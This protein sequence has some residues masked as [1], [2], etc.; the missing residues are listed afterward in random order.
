MKVRER[1]QNFLQKTMYNMQNKDQQQKNNGVEEDDEYYDDDEEYDDEE[2]EDDFMDIANTTKVRPN[3]TTAP[4]P[5]QGDLMNNNTNSPKNISNNNVSKNNNFEEESEFNDDRSVSS[6]GSGISHESEKLDLLTK[7]DNLRSRGHIIRDFDLTSKL[8]DIKKET[9]RVQRQIAVSS[10]IKFQQKMLMALVSGLEYT[11]KRF[12]PFSID[13]DGWSENVFENIEDFNNVFERLYDKYR[14]RGEMAPEI[15][16]M[17]TLAGSAFMF[18]MSNHLFKQMSQPFQGQMRNLRQSVKA[19]FNQTK[20]NQQNT[21][22]PVTSPIP[23]FQ[24]LGASVLNS[25]FKNTTT[26]KP[27][28]DESNVREVQMD[29]F[30]NLSEILKNDKDDDPL[31]DQDRFSIASS[32]SDSVIEPPV[33]VQE[34]KH[35]KKTTKNN[36]KRSIVL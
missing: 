24:D 11:N 6:V 27:S 28:I 23:S 7:L 31:L 19:A 18:N 30:K 26:T 1:S 10:S 15:E 32:S 22:P 14:K 13:L 2:E 25:V 5:L 4:V 8:L 33:R 3:L 21:T 17:L 34:T 35:K 16:L 20:N 12:D 36:N 29:N 9:F